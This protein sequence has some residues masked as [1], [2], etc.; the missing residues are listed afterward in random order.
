[1][2]TAYPI[3]LAH[4]ICPFDK[5]IQPFSDTDNRDDDRFHYFRKIRSTLRQNGFLA[6]HSRVRWASNLERRA[7]DLRKEISRITENFSRWRRVHIIAHSMGGLDARQMIFRYQMQ[8]HVASLTT[9]GTPHLGTA[10]ADW[11]IKRF[12]IF[13][14]MVR[15]FGLNLEG[16]KDLTRRSCQLFN[17][18]TKDFEKNNGV[19]YRTVA[20]VQPLNRIFRPL[21]YS[22][23]IIRREEGENDGLVS[24]KSATWK[25]E[26]LLEILDADHLDQIGWWDRSKGNW[27][28]KETF[29]RHIR[30]FYLRISGGLED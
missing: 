22:Y 30:Q 20:G 18:I 11:G 13:L 4:G 19:L 14:D 8:D 5:L 28:E 12:G 16:F 24:L 3:I 23:R 15:P 2:P 29:E 26:Y 25:D 9:I 7:S 1:V 6:F 10:F 17:N 27:M 21:R